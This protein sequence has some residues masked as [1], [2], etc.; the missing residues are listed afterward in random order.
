MPAINDVAMLTPHPADVSCARL[1]QNVL[2][3]LQ[4]A[5]L[6]GVDTLGK[7]SGWS[8]PAFSDSGPKAHTLGD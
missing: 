1:W 2:A 5:L 6:Y 7:G 4:R 8:D 3:P